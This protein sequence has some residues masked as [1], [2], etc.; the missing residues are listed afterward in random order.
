MER[1]VVTGMGVASP[2]GCTVEDFWRR[3]L[4]GESGVVALDEEHFGGMRSRIGALATGYDPGAYFTRKELRRLSRSSQLAVVAAEQ[5]LAQSCLT[6]SQV[7]PLD[8]AVMVGSS[9]GGFSASDPFFRNYYV[10][11]ATS[12]LV[13][14]LSMNN[15]PSS[16]VSIRFGV[17][18]LFNADPPVLEVNSAPPSPAVLAGGNFNSAANTYFYDMMGR[19]FYLGANFTF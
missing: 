9:I 19:R 3:L 4:A 7:D 2:L 16:N 11:G 10:H 5:A 13:I 1:V 18:N 6:D 12:P 15:G 8:V 14:P 17:E